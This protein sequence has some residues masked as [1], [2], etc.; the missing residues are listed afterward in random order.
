MTCASGQ[1]AFY[2]AQDVAASIDGNSDTKWCVEHG[3]RD[4]VWVADLGASPA[5]APASYAI[6]S[7][8]DVPERDPAAWVL[9][10]S[11]DGKS[12]STLDRRTGETFATRKQ[13][14][15]FH[16]ASPAAHR[17]LRITFAKPADPVASR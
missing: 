5:K 9:E 2:D 1:K 12:W 8:N 16:I 4:V 11:A 10:G 15:T 14:R 7:G 6:T 3:G 17:F 13:S